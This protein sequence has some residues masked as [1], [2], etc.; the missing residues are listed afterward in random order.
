MKGRDSSLDFI[1]GLCILLIIV[2]HCSVSPALHDLL[3]FFHVPVFFI[4]SGYNY[5]FRNLSSEIAVDFRR[6][7]KPLAFVGFTLLIASLFKDLY[8]GTGFNSFFTTLLGLLWGSGFSYHFNF[9]P[10]PKAESIGPLWFLWAMFWTRLFFNRLLLVKNDILKI[11]LVCLTAIFFVNLKQY[12]SLPFSLIPGICATGFFCSGF[13]LKKY[14]V[15]NQEKWNILYIVFII[16]FFLCMIPAGN[17]DVNMSIYK[18]FYLFDVLGVLGVFCG[19]LFFSRKIVLS[20]R[21]CSLF[22]WIG[23]YS[24]VVYCIHALEYNL[25]N[26]CWS[27]NLINYFSRIYSICFVII[28]RIIIAVLGAKL[29]LRIPFLKEK[30]FE[31]KE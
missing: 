6:L 2:G 3:Y 20:G 17:L 8:K 21:L 30:V 15:F 27:T 12:I 5:R 7:L 25:M 1:K 18:G 14:D 31:L 24:L 16:A 19:M 13:L 4:V 26:D 9:L 29:V 22:L 23:K 28:L 10:L 11:I